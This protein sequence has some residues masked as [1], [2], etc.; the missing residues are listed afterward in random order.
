[1]VLAGPSSLAELTAGVP[2]AEPLGRSSWLWTEL[3]HAA[4]KTLKP[5]DPPEQ[6]QQPFPTTNPR[7]IPSARPGSVPSAG[8]ISRPVA[9]S[10]PFT[11]QVLLASG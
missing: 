1:M 7:A 2:F 5:A 8:E 4:A 10:L 9:F 11:G 3:Q 6:P